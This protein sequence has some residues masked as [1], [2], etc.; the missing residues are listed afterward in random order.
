MLHC[1]EQPLSL[2]FDEVTRQLTIKIKRID[3][4][5]KNDLETQILH[6]EHLLFL[7][8]NI[9]HESEYIICEYPINRLSFW[10]ETTQLTYLEQLRLCRNVYHYQQFIQQHI[11]CCLED[12]NMFFDDNLMPTMAHRGII[13]K[14]VPYEFTEQEF[15]KQY[16]ALVLSTLQTEFTFTDIYHGAAALLQGGSIL[17]KVIVATD[18][19]AIYDIL[20]TAYQQ[21]KTQQDKT[22][23]LVSKAFYRLYQISTY[24]FTIFFIAFIGV[25]IYV[26][27][28]VLP[29][30]QKLLQTHDAFLVKDYQTI[31]EHWRKIDI[32]ILP[33]SAQY[34]L[35]YAYLQA[36][37]LTNKQ[38]TLIQNNLSVKSDSN[39]LQY[40]IYSG[41]GMLDEALD[42]AKKL[43][44]VEL[45]IFVLEKQ[46]TL[47]QQDNTLTGSEKEQQVATLMEALNKYNDI[48]Q[49]AFN[50]GG[51]AEAYEA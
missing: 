1:L 22:K 47:T 4:R 18:A 30:Q 48:F 3:T 6:W 24:I 36:E 44:D 43:E 14:I 23:K 19:S 31:I 7:Q 27:G 29:H 35:A 42:I 37:P 32:T 11:T 15:F 20:A 16:Q 39:Y 51:E 41:K 13:D 45:I 21:E 33:P 9:K 46:I 8:A 38:R 50:K 28:V 17:Q 34:E 25:A 49:Q 10:H 2:Y 12:T 5:I 40:W 26:G